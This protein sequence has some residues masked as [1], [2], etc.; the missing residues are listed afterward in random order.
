MMRCRLCG[1]RSGS[2]AAD[3]HRTD[4]YCKGWWERVE[5]P[6]A[7]WPSVLVGVSLVMAAALVMWAAASIG[8]PSPGQIVPSPGPTATSTPTIGVTPTTITIPT[9]TIAPPTHTITPPTHTIAATA[10]T[11]V[12]E[13][14]EPLAG[15]SF[16]AL[17]MP[18]N[19]RTVVGGCASDGFCR[20]WNFYYAPTH[21]VVLVDASQIGASQETHE[22]CHA[23][24]HWAIN[25]GAP[26]AP[27]D[28]DLESWYSTA[29]GR[30]FTSAVAGLVAW[31]WSHSA[32][33]GLEDFAWTCAYW[34][35]DPQRLLDVGGAERYE[36]ARESLP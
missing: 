16:I 6:T 34:Y 18:T 3:L 10:P 2:R 14:P 1:A 31:P 4:A 33:N 29:E 35:L 24:Q 36:W 17:T 21:E 22:Y 20:A 15:G 11:P 27:S 30:G 9:H 26:L 25:G 5:E 13:P 28:Y 12:S 19:V 32:V 8:G 7:W 23:H